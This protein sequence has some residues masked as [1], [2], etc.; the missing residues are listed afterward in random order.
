MKLTRQSLIAA[1][2]LI[3]GGLIGAS[4]LIAFADNSW[5]GAPSQSGCGSIPCS[6][7]AAPLNVGTTAQTKTGGSLQINGGFGIAG[8]PFVFNPGSAPAGYVLTASSSGDGTAVW[9]PGGSN[10]IHSYGKVMWDMLTYNGKTYYGCEGGWTGVYALGTEVAN[11]NNTATG[12][13]FCKNRI[14][15]GL[16]YGSQFGCSN[17]YQ[18]V[19]YFTSVNGTDLQSTGYCVAPL[20]VIN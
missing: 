11:T 17:G 10:V 4:A 20:T 1:S 9:S 8:G 12:A 13:A 2:S 6:N 18:L 19:S 16:D 3:I 15:A 5:V 7:I 14:I